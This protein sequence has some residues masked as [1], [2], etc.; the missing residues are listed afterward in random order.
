MTHPAA[1]DLISLETFHDGL[2][3]LCEGALPDHHLLNAGF[4]VDL[5][6]VW[7]AS[8]TLLDAEGSV[9]P[10]NFDVSEG[11]MI[12]RNTYRSKILAFFESL[13]AIQMPRIEEPA[14]LASATP[15]P[16]P[17]PPP[18]AAAAVA[19]APAPAP[20]SKKRERCGECGNFHKGD[21]CGRRHIGDCPPAPAASAVSPPVT[22]VYNVYD[23][24]VNSFCPP[25]TT[26]LLEFLA[27]IDQL[28]RRTLIIKVML[29]PEHNI[30]ARKFDSLITLELD[31]MG[32]LEEVD[33]LGSASTK[34]MGRTRYY[35]R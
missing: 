24:V 6:R 31:S 22:V 7:E 23:G 19:A 3:V 8:L 10:V 29:H 33:P 15:P 14:A 21:C 25:P 32:V 12:P 30:A 35:V 9:V 16:P 27:L 2:V 34:S 13:K 11:P 18:P 5:Q 17:P 20:A 4:L 1:L 26:S 28:K